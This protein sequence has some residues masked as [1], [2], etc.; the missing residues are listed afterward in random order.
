MIKQSMRSVLYSVTYQAVDG[1][2]YC[3]VFLGK[4]SEDPKRVK[5]FEIMKMGTTPDVFHSI[6]AGS[7]FPVDVDVTYDMRAGSQNKI[8]LFCTAV[9]FVKP[10]PAVKTA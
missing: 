10:Q 9:A 1:K 2:E 4:P 8:T 7:S 6:P 3:S 5:G